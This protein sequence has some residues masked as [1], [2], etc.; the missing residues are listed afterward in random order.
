M[1]FSKK[2]IIGQINLILKLTAHAIETSERKFAMLYVCKTDT[3]NAW[4]ASSI[5]MYIPRTANKPTNR[6]NVQ[7]NFPWD[8]YRI[9]LY[10]QFVD[11]F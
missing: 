8:Y 6:C 2:C 10:I 3:T 7:V 11:H 4:V 1:L 9:S 5:K